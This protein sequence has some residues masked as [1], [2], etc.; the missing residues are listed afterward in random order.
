MFICVSCLCL[1]LLFAMSSEA[2]ARHFRVDPCGLTPNGGSPD[3]ARIL[4]PLT[5]APPRLA[6]ACVC[7]CARARAGSVKRS[8]E[9]Q[10]RDGGSK[11]EPAGNFGL[12]PA[13]GGA[14]G[15]RAVGPNLFG[16]LV[17]LPSSDALLA[18]GSVTFLPEC[19]FPSGSWS[20]S[21]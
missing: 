11:G 18:S 10:Q 17:D 14:G 9:E 2:R 8:P 15:S 5:R 12:T 3:S 4:T 6:C 19:L 20:R 16:L 13:G 21:C 7:V 1:C